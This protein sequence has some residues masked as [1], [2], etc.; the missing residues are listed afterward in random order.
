[1]TWQIVGHDWAVAL[2]SQSLAANRAAHA[3]LLSGPPQ[4][5]KTTLALALAQALNC[6]HPDPPCGRCPS[7]EKI[8]RRSHPDVQ[9]VVGQ[10]AG[11]SIKIDQV[12][13]LQREAALT[14][15]E[16]RY[17]VFILR[18]MDRATVEAANSLLKSLEEPPA[19]V[20][21]VLTAVDV[22]ALP[23]TIVSRCQRLDLRPAP[24]DVVS[25]VLHD[26]GVAP[27]EARLLARLSAGRVGW[28]LQAIEGEAALQQR[29]QRLA[30][31]IELLAADR[32]ARFDFAWKASR[33][34]AA[35]RDQIE[36]WTGWWRDL[37]LLGNRVEDHVLN[38]DRI[39]E[40]RSLARQIPAGQAWATLKAMQTAAV[41]LE[42]NV[43][44]RLAL[45]NLM[46]RL[47]HL[48]P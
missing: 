6:P 21:L 11:E 36:L 34:V 43:N 18:H 45:E 47:P 26:R 7:C 37:L 22:E 19:S 13:T 38:V 10:G 1:M 35:S 29:Q 48:Q 41:Q 3:Y 40:L 5:G 27:A 4:I 9:V 28:A 30:C 24:H 8:A 23:S 20:V 14:P 2:L 42:A 16:G 31:L 25:E 32:V 17:R 15:Y 46:L 12:R 44:A 39:D 33:D